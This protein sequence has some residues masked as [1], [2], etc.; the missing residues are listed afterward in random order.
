MTDLD[1]LLR[2]HTA[3]WRREPVAEP[4]LRV[5]PLRHRQRLENTDVSPDMLDVDALTP[6][7]GT[8]DMGKHLIQGDLI[9]GECAW[10]GVPWMEAIIGCEIH[11]GANEAM[12]A[13]PALGPNYEGLERIIPSDDNV[14]LRKLLDLTRTLVEANDGSYVVT[15]TLQ[16]GPTDMLSALL[17][18][19]RMGLA[20]YDEPGRVADVLARTAQAFIKV[21]KAQ[22]ALIEPLHGG[23][24]PWTYGLWAPGSVIRFQSDSSSQLSPR[25]YREHILPHDREIMR[26]FDYSLIDLHS[27]GTLHLHSVLMEVEE[28]GAVSV[29][30]DRYANAPTVEHLLPTLSAVLQAKSLYI[31]GEMT[32]AEL[33]LLRRELPARGLAINAQI[34]DRLLWERPV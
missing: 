27:A 22:Y 5:S 15:H 16:R 8:R 31:I 11:A 1:A 13:R 19:N 28:L 30:L 26:A 14:W 3:F 17:G 29:T 2:R 25:M 18:D 7:V 4:L 6:L 10:S 34:T 32:I 9:H 33:D 24:V 12:W 20:L 21:A 23:W